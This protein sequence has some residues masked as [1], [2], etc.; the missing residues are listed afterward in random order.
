MAGRRLEYHHCGYGN[1]RVKMCYLNVKIAAEGE[2][3]M[4]KHAGGCRKNIT[5]QE[6]RYAFLMEQKCHS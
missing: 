2:N 1:G 6:D 5:P 3:A 4:Q